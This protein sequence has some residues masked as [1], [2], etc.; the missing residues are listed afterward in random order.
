MDIVRTFLLTILCVS[1]GKGALFT[2]YVT[3]KYYST[4]Y[5]LHRVVAFLSEMTRLIIKWLFA[6]HS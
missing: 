2:V 3:Y 5:F 6:Q 1:T 4:A